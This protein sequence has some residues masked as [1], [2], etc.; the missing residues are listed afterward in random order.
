MSAVSQAF[1][2]LAAWPASNS[3]RSACAS[4]RL[5]RHHRESFGPAPLQPRE[6]RFLPDLRQLAMHTEF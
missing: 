5:G 6:K 2:P 1:S 4:R 3:A